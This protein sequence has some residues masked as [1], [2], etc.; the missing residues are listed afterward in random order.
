MNIKHRAHIVIITS[1]MAFALVACG[2][3]EEPTVGQQLDNAITNTEQ[4]MNEARQDLQAAASDLRR[5]GEQAAQSVAESANDMA[6]TAKVKTALAAD[7]QLSALSIQVDTV[8][9]VVSLSGPAPSADAVERA[10]VLAR[11]VDGVNAVENRLVVEG[12]S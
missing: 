8:D 5:E 11:A 1:T 6:I 2:Q 12:K 10:T 3:K 7:D 9:G 4:A